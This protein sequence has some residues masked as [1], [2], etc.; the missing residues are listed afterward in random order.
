MVS[1]KPA[2][3]KPHIDKRF[4]ALYGVGSIDNLNSMFASIRKKYVT[5][6]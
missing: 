6:K 4:A 5:P 1:N 3:K 2:E